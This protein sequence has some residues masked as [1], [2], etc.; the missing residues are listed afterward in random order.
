NGY[1]Q[2]F[3]GDIH[4]DAPVAQIDYDHEKGRIAVT[5]ENSGSSELRLKISSNA[6]DHGEE[7]SIEIAPGNKTKKSW[8]LAGSGN[9]YDFTMAT[10]SGHVHRFAGRVEAGRHS[11]SGPAMAADI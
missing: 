2:K 6:Y 7:A 5:L 1:F 4:L 11:I 9:W 10:T 3:A 8:D